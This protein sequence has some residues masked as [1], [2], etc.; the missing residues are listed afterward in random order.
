MNGLL[1]MAETTNALFHPNWV[2]WVSGSTGSCLG[3][4]W[5]PHTHKEGQE[6]KRKKKREILGQWWQTKKSEEKKKK[7][8]AVCFH[9]M[10]SLTRWPSCCLSHLSFYILADSLP[11]NTPMLKSWI[12]ASRVHTIRSSLI[13]QV[14]C[15]LPLRWSLLLLYGILTRKRWERMA[16]TIPLK[17]V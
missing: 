6:K 17:N 1:V 5:A 13:R 12:W 3:I 8:E 11:Y 16:Q 15:N 4:P 10:S 7:R 9:E 14:R 2:G